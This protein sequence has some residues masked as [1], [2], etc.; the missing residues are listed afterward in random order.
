MNRLILTLT[1]TDTLRQLLSGL[2]LGAC[3]LQD[4]RSRKISIVFLLVSGSIALGV[5]FC[6]CIR[7]LSDPLRCLAAVVP[8]ALLLVLACAAKGWAGTGDGICFMI[9]GA[10]LGGR[11]TLLVMMGALLLASA[12]SMSLLAVRKVTRKTRLPFLAF[13]AVV[14]AGFFVSGAGVPGS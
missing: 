13:A 6:L 8:G 14:W 1:E 7:G 2:F 5:D 10:V 11:G 9:L 12:C 3:G 4:L